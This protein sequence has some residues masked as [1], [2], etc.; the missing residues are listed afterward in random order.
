M[1]KTRSVT[2]ADKTL[3]REEFGNVS[4]HIPCVHVSPPIAVVSISYIRG[5]VGVV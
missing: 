4:I 2:R 5:G 1:S 3:A